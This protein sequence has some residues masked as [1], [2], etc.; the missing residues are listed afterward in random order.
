MEQSI[1]ILE[2]KDFFG[3]K[4]YYQGYWQD[5]SDINEAKRYTLDEAL[6][7]SRNLKEFGGHYVV[8]RINN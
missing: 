2:S 8:Q 6:A 7:E 1:Y 4:M 3:G 5:T